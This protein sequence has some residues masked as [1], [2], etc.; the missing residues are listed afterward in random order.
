MLM[1]T[2]SDRTMRDRSRHGHVTTTM[3]GSGGHHHTRRRV[4]EPQ[5]YSDTQKI[6]P[7]Y[8]THS[9]AESE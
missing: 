8:R 4:T 3:H 2:T 7:R 5:R 6:M 9:C 1:T